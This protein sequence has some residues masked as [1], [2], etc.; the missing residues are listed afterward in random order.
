M[1]AA[2]ARPERA[3]AEAGRGH[4]LRRRRGRRRGPGP[5]DGDRVS[6]MTP[7]HPPEIE[8]LDPETFEVPRRLSRDDCRDH[9]GADDFRR[10]LLTDPEQDDDR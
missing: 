4:D 8:L 9:I 6:L 2:R 1:R 7:D 5:A 10:A 3:G